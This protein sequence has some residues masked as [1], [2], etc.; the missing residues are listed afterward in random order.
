M[1]EDIKND[2]CKR[3]D[4]YADR[5]IEISRKI[6]GCPEIRFQEHK[7]AE[8]ICDFFSG[9]KFIVDKGIG[10]IDTA[11]RV[12]YKKKNKGKNVAFIARTGTCMWS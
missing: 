4:Q 2:V 1:I 8:W 6:H 12:E 9:D 5:I 10:N 3:V 11:F 7:A